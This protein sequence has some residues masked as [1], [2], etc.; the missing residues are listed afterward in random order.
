MTDL[1]A[2]WICQSCYVH[3]VTPDDVYGICG[4]P[5][6]VGYLC[7]ECGHLSDHVLLSRLCE[8]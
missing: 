1:P 4:E 7:E 6:S 8:E 5:H 3:V 2:R